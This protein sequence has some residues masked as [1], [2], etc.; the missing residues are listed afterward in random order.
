MKKT[1]IISIPMLL[2]SLL[3]SGC[4]GEDQDAGAAIGSRNAVL[5]TTRQAEVT[6]LPIWLQSAG[7]VHSLSEPTL[8]AEVEGRITNVTADTGDIRLNYGWRCLAILVSN[9]I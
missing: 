3:L 4:G 8:A 6:D 9:T 1:Q 5:V 2:V 7:Q